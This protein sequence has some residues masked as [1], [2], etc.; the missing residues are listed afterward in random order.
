MRRMPAVAGLFY[1]SSPGELRS[2]VLELLSSVPE[3][4]RRDYVAAIVPHAGYVYS[5]SVA[6]HAYRALSTVQPE[7]VV[8]VGP[9]HTGLGAA[10]SVWPDGEWVTPL[11]PVE[12]DAALAEE[13]IERSAFAVADYEAH[14]REHSIEVQLPFLQCIY[15]DFDFVPIV[16]GYQE[17]DAAKDIASSIPAGNLLIASSDFSHYVPAEV[18]RELDMKAIEYILNLDAKGFYSF[19]VNNGVSICGAGPIMAAIEFAR[20]LGAEAELLAFGNSGDTT[21]DYSSVVDYAAIVFY[22]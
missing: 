8:V 7:G 2:I 11:G 13:V 22:R 4:P 9:N 16:M 5:G 10:V 15:G 20:L 1:P 3:Y 21:G 12:I 14:I 17:Y 6:A 19:V 18:G